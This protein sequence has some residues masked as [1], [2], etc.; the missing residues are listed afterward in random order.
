MDEYR[1]W[2][3]DE[4]KMCGVHYIN[5][6][7]GEAGISIRDTCTLVSLDSVHLMKNTHKQDI[8]GADVYE[9]DFIES[10]LGGEILDIRMLV[11]YGAYEA[12]CPADKCYMENVGFYVEAAGYPQMP[13]GPL[14]DYA[15]TIGNIYKNADWLDG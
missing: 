1:A 14:Q 15:K 7:T 2:N 3:A 4:K 6:D 13:L 11:K 9:G 5:W 10:H 8:S 12:Y